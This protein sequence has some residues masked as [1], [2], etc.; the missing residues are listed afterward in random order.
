MQGH[1]V[2]NP[3]MQ[4]YQRVQEVPAT[5]RVIISGTP[6]QNNLA[7]MYALFNLATPVRGLQLALAEQYLAC[8]TTVQ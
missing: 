3:K 4:L 8:I 2:K 7:E 6:I 5:L 1:K